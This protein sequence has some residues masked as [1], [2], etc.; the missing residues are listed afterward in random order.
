MNDDD[1][2]KPL[3]SHV[4]AAQ[5]EIREAKQI[6]ADQDATRQK[7]GGWPAA[8][9]IVAVIAL[10]GLVGAL[11]WKHDEL[12]YWTMGPSPQTLRAD[13]E[14]LMA[15][16]AQDV[17]TYRDRMGSLPDELPNP[18]L[19]QVVNYQRHGD[20]QYTLSGTL[21]RITLEQRY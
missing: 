9:N 20:A 4:L 16:A 13:L 6:A 5:D 8:R 18:A 3:Q 21:G 11:A 12:R 10:V 7:P 2:S 19:A 15:E 1:Q 17:N 14:A